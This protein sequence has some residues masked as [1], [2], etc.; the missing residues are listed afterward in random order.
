M[1]CPGDWDD[2]ATLPC[3]MVTVDRL[4]SMTVFTRVASTRSFSGAARELGI[5]QATASKHVQTLEDWLGV[6]LLHRTTRR[7][8]LNTA[9]RLESSIA[10]AP[11][12][13]PVKRRK[14]F[15]K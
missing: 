10:N 1:G 5:S 3:W 8:A 6:R 13:R 15:T 4:T 9:V 2:G 11:G 7:I 14:S 12:V